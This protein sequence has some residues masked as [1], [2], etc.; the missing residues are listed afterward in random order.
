VA[1]P[2]LGHVARWGERARRLPQCSSETAAAIVID[3][4]GSAYPASGGA[5][6][7]TPPLVTGGLTNLTAVA[8]DLKA[9]YEYVLNASY[10]RP[11]P[12]T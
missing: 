7:Y 6:P 2:G 1:Y 12:S 10:A 11:F 5:F 9:P 4:N 3:C 8:S